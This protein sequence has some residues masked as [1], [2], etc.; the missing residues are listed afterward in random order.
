MCLRLE[1]F[2][3]RPQYAVALYGTC[4]GALSF[5]NVSQARGLYRKPS[6][7]NGFV[8]YMYCWGAEF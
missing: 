3:K 6:V 8:W 2:L 5:E 1:A 7:C 4:T